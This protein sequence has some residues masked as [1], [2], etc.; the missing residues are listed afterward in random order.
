MPFVGFCSLR[1]HDYGDGCSDHVVSYTVID[2]LCSLI[3]FVPSVFLFLLY[4][5]VFFV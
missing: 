2:A 3:C 4:V 5:S 1:L